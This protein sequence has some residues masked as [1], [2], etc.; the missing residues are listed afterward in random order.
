MAVGKSTI[1]RLRIGRAGDHVLVSDCSAP[2]RK[3]IAPP[4]LMRRRPM[5]QSQ[6]RQNLIRQ[7]QTPQKLTLASPMQKIPRKKSSLAR[8]K[9]YPSRN[10]K[11]PEKFKHLEEVLLRM[12]QNSTPPAIPPGA[13]AEEKSGPA[14]QR[15]S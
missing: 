1:A 9:T 3:R 4:N 2:S 11:S 15:G 6:I 5:R 13:L 10:V 14:K 12:R 7:S 8:P